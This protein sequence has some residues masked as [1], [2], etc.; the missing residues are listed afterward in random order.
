MDKYTGFEITVRCKSNEIVTFRSTNR[1]S[2]IR[3][4]ENICSLPLQLTE[5]WNLLVIDLCALC[6]RVFSLEY[7]HCLS[8]RI[9]GNC[10]VRRIYFSKEIYQEW[11]LPEEYKVFGMR[12]PTLIQ[13]GM[14]MN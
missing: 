3:L 7:K 8:I 1:Q 9:F 13:G 10:R 11:E 4:F 2:T 14:S 5:S 6:K 12:N